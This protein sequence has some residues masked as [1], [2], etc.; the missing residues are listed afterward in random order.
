[1]SRQDVKHNADQKLLGFFAARDGYSLKDFVEAMHL[2]MDEFEEMKRKNALSF[3][4]KSMNDIE[5][6]IELSN[7]QP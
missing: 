1:M 5:R 2:T 3:S 7:Y 4:E 6:A